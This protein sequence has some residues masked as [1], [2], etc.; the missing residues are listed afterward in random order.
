MGASRPVTRS[1]RGTFPRLAG[2]LLGVALG[3]TIVISTALPLAW[4]SATLHLKPAAFAMRSA[5]STQFAW[6]MIGSG[7][8][9]IPRLGVSFASSAEPIAPIASLTKLMTAYVVLHRLPL[10]LSS[11]GPC[12][13]VSSDDVATYQRDVA[14]DQSVIKVN[15]GTELCERDLL[16]GLFVHSAN[17]FAELLVRL[18][19]FTETDFVAAMNHN[20]HGLAMDSTT[21]VD[22][23]GVDPRDRSTAA[24]LMK[25]VIPLMNVPLVR[26][27]VAQSTVQI[28]GAGTVT[29]YTPMLGMN[30]VVGIKSGRTDDAGGCDAM[31]VLTRRG[32]STFLTYSVVIGQRGPNLLKAAGTAARALAQ[33]AISQVVSQTWRR[34]SQLGTVGWPNAHSP[35][36]VAHTVTA[37]WWRASASPS[38]LLIA[39]PEL[40]AGELQLASHRQFL[41][42]V[43]DGGLA[44]KFPTQLSRHLLTINVIVAVERTRIVQVELIQ[45]HRLHRPAWWRAVL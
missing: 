41:R 32:Q 45:K 18:C 22:V 9:A 31:A 17:N 23:S 10:S 6:P 3:S 15:A 7:A 5:P 20:A 33:S 12:L 14:D 44:L 35:V 38:V 4:A 24:D 29:T 34:G 42:A 26:Q 40:T 25:V 21:Y 37:L 19:G 16:N 2:A 13:I 27:I 30:G 8:V 28:P 43:R 39:T 36:L 11:S 1:I